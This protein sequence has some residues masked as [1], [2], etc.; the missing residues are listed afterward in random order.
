[1][2]IVVLPLLDHQRRYSPDRMAP[3]VANGSYFPYD[4]KCDI[5][6]VGATC[7]EIADMKPPNCHIAPMQACFPFYFMVFHRSAHLS[8]PGAPRGYQRPATYARAPGSVERRLQGVHRPV[9][10]E[11]A[12]ETQVC[13]GAIE[14]K[15][16]PFYSSS[17]WPF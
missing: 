11:G 8:L 9:H 2:H 7:L 17:F 12:P 13:R 14:G 3:E 5:W 1:M 4:E 15:C 6:S 10:G 16:V